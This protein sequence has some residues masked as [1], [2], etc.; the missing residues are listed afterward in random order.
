MTS[1]DKLGTDIKF[2]FLLESILKWFIR[3]INRGRP[4]T[5]N[6][7]NFRI[8]TARTRTGTGTK[9]SKDVNFWEDED[10][11]EVDIL[12]IPDFEPK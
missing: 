4:R 2:Q 5:T 6:F 12:R 1:E 3:N 7:E 11:E 8:S 10:G 9:T